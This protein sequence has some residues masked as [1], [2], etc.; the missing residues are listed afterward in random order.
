MTSV[1]V[2]IMA[3]K[4]KYSTKKMSYSGALMNSAKNTIKLGVVTGVGSGVLGSIGAMAP[5]SAPALGAANTALGLA[6]IGNMASVGMTVAG[7]PNTLSKKK[8]KKKTYGW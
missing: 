2:Y 7:M 6:N 1:I 4:K 3:R 5:G 8:G